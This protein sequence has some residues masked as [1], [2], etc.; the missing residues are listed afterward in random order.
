VLLSWRDEVRIALCPERVTLARVSRRWQPKVIAKHVVH[1]SP[2]ATSDWKP[3]V[4]ALTHALQELMW[5]NADATV[6]ISNNF[7]RYALVPWS[8]HLS[9]GEEKLAWVK[10]HFVE[11]HGETETPTEYRWSEDRP[12]APCV[13]S[14]VDGEL[15][16]QI[17]AAFEPTSLRLRSIQPY[18][19]TVFNRWKRRLRG[20]PAWI[21]VPE[22]GRICLASIARGKWRTISSRKTGLD[23]QAELSEMLGRELLLADETSAPAVILAYA[24]EIARLE[25]ADSSE[26]P[27]QQ[28][29]PKALPGFLPETDAQF[30]MALTGVA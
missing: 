7:V 14:A 24:P 23:W 22:T 15:L 1:C 2:A 4:D 6:V 16:A 9:S 30:A 5:Q 19:M 18:L 29:Q 13:A 28:L 3:S 21:V 20:D 11:L 27:L 8:E 26:I 10:H 25:I 12:D 17:R